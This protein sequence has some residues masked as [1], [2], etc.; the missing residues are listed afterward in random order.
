MKFTFDYE[1]TLSRRVTIDAKNFQD[2]MNQLYEM[3]DNCD[4]VLSADD[5]SSGKIS[6]PLGKNLNFV[7]R[8]EYLGEEMED[9]DSEDYDMVL[10]WW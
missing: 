1:E 2:A 6:I 3:I 4:L 10:D 8:L 9:T 7:P 5:F